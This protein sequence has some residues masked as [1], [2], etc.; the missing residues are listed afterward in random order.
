MDTSFYDI[1]NSTTKTNIIY[2][3]RFISFIQRLKQHFS[4]E[5][6][7]VMRTHGDILEFADIQNKI[8]R[9]FSIFYKTI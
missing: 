7:N 8:K 4:V 2:N 9:L 1:N 3:M 5:I 6:E